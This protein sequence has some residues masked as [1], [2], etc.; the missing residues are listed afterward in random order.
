M[1]HLHRSF[2]DNNK[3][4]AGSL[5]G[6]PILSGR[7]RTLVQGNFPVFIVLSPG[8]RTSVTNYLYYDYDLRMSYLV[9]VLWSPV[10][11]VIYGL[12]ERASMV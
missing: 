10:S 6:C 12:S 1:S 3:N 5:Q 11:D 8:S 7:M 4:L 2:Q 9:L